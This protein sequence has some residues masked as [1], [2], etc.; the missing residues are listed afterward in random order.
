MQ[1]DPAHVQA[2]ATCTGEEAGGGEVDGDAGERD[3]EHDPAAHVGR[4]DEP[5]D[6]R[7]D[8]PHADEQEG[9]AVRLGGEDL[10]PREAEGEAAARRPAGHR[11]RDERERDRAD[12]REQV[13]RVGEER[14]R[15]G[16]DSGRD[17]AR[18][19]AADEDGRGRERPAVGGEP[20]GVGVHQGTVA[21]AQA[22]P[23]AIRLGAVGCVKSSA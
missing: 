12:V 3:R 15:A 2:L 21:R 6:G 18:H 19:E 4:L 10:E 14:E 23:A 5:A 20:L 7:V 1:E 22:R 11:R 9:D 13:P 17:L 8:D 16:D